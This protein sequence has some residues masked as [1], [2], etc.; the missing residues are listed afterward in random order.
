M[1]PAAGVG[2]DLMPSGAPEGVGHR[3][4]SSPAEAVALEGIGSPSAQSRGLMSARLLAVWML[5]V[6]AI[7]IARCAQIG[8]L[9]PLY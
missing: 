5:S 8:I 1:L 2:A 9:D 4:I 7:R 3:G 6:V